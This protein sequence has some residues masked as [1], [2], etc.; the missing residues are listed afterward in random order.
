MPFL[1]SVGYEFKAEDIVA[2]EFEAVDFTRVQP[3]VTTYQ[4]SLAHYF[5]TFCLFENFFKVTIWPGEIDCR[6]CEVA[7]LSAY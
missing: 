5:S 3:F 2:A 7:S 1:A 6:E 4:I